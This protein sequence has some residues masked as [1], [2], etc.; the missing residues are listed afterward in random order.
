MK[1]RGMTM[2]ILG[3][4]EQEKS[5]RNYKLP[6]LEEEEEEESGGGGVK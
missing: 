5:R 3:T 2:K 4:R 6:N 1:M